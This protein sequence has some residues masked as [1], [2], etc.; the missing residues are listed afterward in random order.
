MQHDEALRRGKPGRPLP[1][2]VGSKFG[3]ERIIDGDHPFPAT[4]ADHSQLAAALVD[5]DE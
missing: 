1:G 4:L 5:T 2:E 3:E